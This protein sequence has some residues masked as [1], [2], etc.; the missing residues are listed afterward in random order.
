MLVTSVLLLSLALA[1]FLTKKEQ[2]TGSKAV[3][4]NV[5]LTLST[6]RSTFVP[7]ETFQVSINVNTN[8]L[9]MT[10]AELYL[11]Y[12]KDLLEA[13]SFQKGT[14]LPTV[15]KEG[16]FSNT[17]GTAS[18]ALGCGIGET[19][20]SPFNGSGQLAVLTFKSKAVGTANV[21]LSGTTLVAVLEKEG[22]VASL[23]S[24]LNLV[25]NNPLG[26]LNLKLKFQGISTKKSD[27]VIKVVL[28][29]A[30]VEKYRFDSVTVSF[31]D[32]GIAQGTIRNIT[33]GTY[34][35]YIKGW[36]HLTRK[37]SG[38]VI[39]SAVVDKDLTGVVIRT[40][41]ATADDKVNIQDFGIL[42]RD[43]SNVPQSP[44]DFDLSGVVNIQDFGYMVSNYLL[45]GEQ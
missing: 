19:G 2:R 3:G 25:I 6:G 17:T 7:G 28:K 32:T 22:N 38:V 18:I 34:D 39:S 16:S 24:P 43:Y 44:A 35:I 40:G 5:S 1:V 27:K 20:A 30:G 41:D 42:V 15:L 45:Q 21:S 36:S 23:G 14:A 29:Q 10:G 33:P 26:G 4:E 11:N 13:T 37:F 8:N 31:N 9:N 12:S